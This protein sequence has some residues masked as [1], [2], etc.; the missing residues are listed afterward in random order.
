MVANVM[1]SH[2]FKMQVSFMDFDILFW[3]LDNLLN[4]LP[5]AIGNLTSLRTVDISGTNQ[6]FYLPKTFCQ[7]QT[8]EVLLLAKPHCMEY[9]PPSM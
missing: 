6:V 5:K 9:P 8:L 3:I 7:L 4:G 1:L 2:S